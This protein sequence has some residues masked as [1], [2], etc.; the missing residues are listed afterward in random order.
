VALVGPWNL[1]STM[2]EIAQADHYF[3]ANDLTTKLQN[4]Y[5]GRVKAYPL[6]ILSDTN[7]WG[8]IVNPSLADVIEMGYLNGRQEPEMFVADSPQSEQVFVADAIRHKIRHEYAGAV[9]DGNTGYKAE[10]A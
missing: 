1:N 3:S 6:S 5:K 8:L 4:P 7:D 10:V 9:V 2:L